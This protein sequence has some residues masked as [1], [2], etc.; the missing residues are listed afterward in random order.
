MTDSCDT[1]WIKRNSREQS[2]VGKVQGG[3][4]CSTKER[5]GHEVGALLPVRVGDKD[6]V[7]E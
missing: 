1:C 6:L 5:W 3:S 4:Q 7:L 2:S